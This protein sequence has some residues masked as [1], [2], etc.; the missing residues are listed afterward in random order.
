MN[1]SILSRIERLEAG[2]LTRSQ[3]IML[4][5]FGKVD[6]KQIM[7]MSITDLAEATG[8]AEATVLRFCRSLG[9]NGY[10]EFKLRLAQDNTDV[11]GRESGGGYV[12]DIMEDYRAAIDN[13]RAN[14]LPEQMEKVFEYIL[15]ARSI[16]CFGV[17]HSYLAALELHNRLMKM[18]IVTFCERDT[19][20]QSILI[21]SRTPLD[22]LIVFSIS[23]ATKDV[24]EAAELARAYGMKIIVVTCYEKS[25]LTRFAD[26][27]LSA[28]SMESPVEPGAMSSK[29]MQLFMVDVIC[30]GVHLTDKSRFDGFIAKSNVATVG[31]LI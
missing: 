19:H 18:G 4:E 3:R 30:T 12:A 9:F 20:F 23:G 22:L 25:P 2:K 8:L 17:G 29:I 10:Q 24:V 15:S 21:S 31:K 13:C 5:Y 26:I 28:T 7:Y 16:C 6:F 1:G 14:I 11:R 27:I